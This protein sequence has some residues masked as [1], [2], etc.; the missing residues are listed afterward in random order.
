MKILIKN[1]SKVFQLPKGKWLSVLKN[2]DFSVTKGEFV[3]ILGETGCGKSTLLKILAGL[4]FPS[5]GEIW[6]GSEK[7]NGPNPS[8]SIVFQNPT[9][10]PWLNVSENI[11]FGCKIRGELENLDQ[12]IAGFIKLMGLTGFEKCHPPELSVGMAHRVALARAFIAKPDLLLLDEPF[13][14]LDTVTRTYLQGELT[15]IW[16]REK[17]TVVFI[18]HDIEEALIMGGKIVLL[19]GE[20]TGIRKVFDVDLSYPRDITNHFFIQTRTE[21]LHSFRHCVQ[22]RGIHRF[23]ENSHD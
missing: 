2:I 12:R 7:I 19:G 11:A 17:F 22:E 9:L 8:R 16:Q 3:V 14:A 21:I 15:S 18:T 23:P 6:A 13:G 1:L 4:D 20:P 5:S 10:L